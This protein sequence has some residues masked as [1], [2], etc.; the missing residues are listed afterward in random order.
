M[1]RSLV[2]EHMII[3]FFSNNSYIE[4]SRYGFWTRAFNRTFLFG[5]P[6]CRFFFLPL[7][8]IFHYVAGRLENRNR[9]VWT[10]RSEV[11]KL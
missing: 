2:N 3:M 10:I 5:K 11:S 7:A 8:R 6:V 1:E 9:L 4:P